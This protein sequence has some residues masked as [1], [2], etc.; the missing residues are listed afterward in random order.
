M[1]QQLMALVALT[2]DQFLAPTW[3]FTTTCDLGSRGYNDF[4]SL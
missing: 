4:L 1:F 3:Q 2:V